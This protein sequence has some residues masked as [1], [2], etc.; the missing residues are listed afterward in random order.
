[1]ASVG[2]SVFSFCD[3]LEHIVV[4]DGNSVCDS[5]DNCNAV[6]ET[7][8]N[9]LLCGCKN[10]IIPNSVISIGNYAFSRC[11]GLTSVTISDNVTEIGDGAFSNCRNLASITIGNNVTTIGDSAFE[12]C[13]GL[14]LVVI[15]NNVISIGNYAFYECFRVYSITIGK[16]VREIGKGAFDTCNSLKSIYC[17]A[18]R[19]PTTGYDVFRN[20]DIKTVTLH[21][22]AASLEDYNTTSPWDRFYTIVGDAIEEQSFEVDGIYYDI[23]SAEE[24][25]VAVTY[26]GKGYD[27]YENEYSGNVVIPESITYEGVTYR[28]ASIGESAF[29]DCSALSSVTIPNSVTQLGRSAFQN[30]SGLASITIGNSVTDIFHNVFL[31]CTALT[32]INIP[33]NVA[34]IG[35]NIFRGCTSLTTV[36]VADGLTYIGSSMFLGCTSLTSVTIPNSVTS[37]DSHA[38]ER[39]YSLASITIP[40]G[41]IEIGFQAF[42]ACFG[43]K[44][45]YCLAKT[46]PSAGPYAFSNVEQSSAT[47]RVPAA[48]L[49]DY[50]TTEPLE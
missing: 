45:V 37:I 41:V 13:Y 28:V 20:V 3:A 31:G 19:V 14:T 10:T 49:Q 30:C 11:H 1:M 16:G 39:C 38:F 2:N 9:K 32:S 35:A 21:V 48:S 33:N 23:T 4:A 24:H 42:S 17:L 50:S 36:T 22:P 25:T 43:L 15:P 44:D 27:E 12:S 46:V 29:R 7:A 6:I 34:K 26:K 8:S 5:R 18:E 47:L 40:S